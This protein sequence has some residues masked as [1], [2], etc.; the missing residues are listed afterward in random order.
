MMIGEQ[1]ACHRLHLVSRCTLRCTSQVLVCWF[2][3]VRTL[4]ASEE[5][6]SKGVQQSNESV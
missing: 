5:R 2:L 6:Q 4:R 1:G 3:V